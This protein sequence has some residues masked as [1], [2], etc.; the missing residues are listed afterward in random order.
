MAEGDGLYGITGLVDDGSLTLGTYEGLDFEHW[1]LGLVGGGGGAGGG[2]GGGG[3][4]GG[5]TLD[6]TLPQLHDITVPTQSNYGQRDEG[7]WPAFPIS[8]H[9]TGE[10][11]R[12][13]TPASSGI[14]HNA[15][16][17]PSTATSTGAVTPISTSETIS[18]S[19]NGN[20]NQL[21]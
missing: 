12:S 9:L 10:L 17:A 15:I 5:G 19:A 8:N 2:G 1:G 16:P 21:R 14:L 7:W 18:S 6:W 4:G 13:H 3:E 11:E 20:D